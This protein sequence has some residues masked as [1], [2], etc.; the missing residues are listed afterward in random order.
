VLV[1]SKAISR[2]GS[3][4]W[5][6]IPWYEPTYQG[7]KN[8]QEK[9]TSYEKHMLHVDMNQHTRY[10]PTYQVWTN[11]PVYEPTYQGM[12][13]LYLGEKLVMSNRPQPLPLKKTILPPTPKLQFVTGDSGSIESCPTFYT[14]QDESLLKGTAALIVL[15][16]LRWR[17]FK[18]K[19]LHKTL[20]RFSPVWSTNVGSVFLRNGPAV[21]TLDLTAFIYLRINL[22]RVSFSHTFVVSKLVVNRSQQFWSQSYDRELQRQRCNF[23]QRHG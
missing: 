7:I 1:N 15:F 11:I 18:L 14:Q 5:H 22:P 13:H 3:R 6:N 8:I 9:H 19:Y 4:I 20:G 12:K 16:F 21:R 23:L 10:E 2:I 17:H